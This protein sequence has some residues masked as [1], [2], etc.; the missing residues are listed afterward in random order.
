MLCRHGLRHPESPLLHSSVAR[1]RRTDFE[2]LLLVPC[3]VQFELSNLGLDL[4]L[5]LRGVGRLLAFAL[6]GGRRRR[7]RVVLCGCHGCRRD[8]CTAAG[9]VVRSGLGRRRLALL[10]DGC[11]EVVTLPCSASACGSPVLPPTVPP[12]MH[13]ISRV[14][15][16][17]L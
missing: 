3:L 17:G 12:P 2:F 14:P 16:T 1:G 7:R 15:N 13:S 11:H 9:F 5:L 10:G 4:L 6:L 8:R